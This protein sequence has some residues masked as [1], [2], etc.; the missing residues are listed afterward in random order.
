MAATVF[1]SADVERVRYLECISI[2][3]QAIAFGSGTALTLLP[4]KARVDSLR[5]GIPTQLSS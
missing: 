5:E 3:D 4:E 2:S 1:P